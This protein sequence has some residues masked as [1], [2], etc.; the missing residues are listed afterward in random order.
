MRVVE[1]VEAG[2]VHHMIV[3]EEDMVARVGVERVAIRL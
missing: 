2:C 3:A 1:V